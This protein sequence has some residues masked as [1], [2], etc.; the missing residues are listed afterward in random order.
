MEADIRYTRPLTHPDQCAEDLRRRGR[1][2]CDLLRCS[3]GEV[4]DLSGARMR[5]YYKGAPF[6][7]NGDRIRT[8]LDCPA[9]ELL[10]NARVCWVRKLGFRR[11]TLGLEFVGVTHEDRMALTDIAHSAGYRRLLPTLGTAG[12]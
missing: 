12:R 5:V 4:V 11:S 8:I 3:L 10:V 6:A 2:K 9:G 7:G 1:V